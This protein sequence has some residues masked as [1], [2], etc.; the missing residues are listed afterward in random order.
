[1]Y[2]ILILVVLYL[3]FILILTIVATHEHVPSLSLRSTTS[4]DG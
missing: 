4:M 3:C 1:L 2:I